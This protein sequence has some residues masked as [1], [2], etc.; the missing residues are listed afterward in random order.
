MK[1][2]AL[3]TAALSERLRRPAVVHW[4]RLEPRPRSENFDRSLRA[5]VRDALW[6]L[7]RQW[8][9]GEFRGEDAGS[10]VAAELQVETTRLTRYAHR[11]G[12]A[13]AYD[14]ELPLEAKVEREEVPLDLALRLQ[15]GHHWFRLLEQKGLTNKYRPLFRG[16]YAVAPP[17]E[18]SVAAAAALSNRA[19]LQ[20][21]AAAARRATDGGRLLEDL[22]S[23]ARAEDVTF[24]VPGTTQVLSVDAADRGAVAEAAAE[25]VAYF[26]RL[27]SQPTKEDGAAWSPEHLEYQFACS[28]PRRG[29]GQTVL[30]A[31]EYYQ[32]RLDW[33]SFDLAPDDTTLPDAKGQ[34]FN[35]NVIEQERISFIPTEVRF[36]GMP[37]ARWWEFEDGRTDFGSV[38]AHTTDIAKLL[39]MEF[40]LVYGNDWSLVPL[41]T[42]AGSISEIKA[43]VVTD[44]F[45]QRTLVR[46]AAHSGGDDTAAQRWRMFTLT[47]P[48]GGRRADERLFLPPAVGRAL[49]GP[50]VESVNF[51]RD[52]MANMVWAV[53][54]TIP[55][56]LGGGMNGY[57]AATDLLEFIRRHAPPPA[58]DPGRVENDARI[59]YRLATTVPE[60]WIPF[61]PVHLEGSTRE[62]QLQRAAMPRVVGGLAPA[63][64]TPRGVILRPADRTLYFVHEEEV[65][66][67]GAVIT[68]SFQRTRWHG[69]ATRLWL[70]RRKENGRGEGSSGLRFDQLVQQE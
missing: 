44:V 13:V 62:I 42:P 4:N 66:R 38:D 53:E 27:F 8:Q 14:G 32:G 21:R 49:E 34:V 22:H 58:P 68:R 56:D 7:T 45:G 6:L 55:D 28:A 64:V 46:S 50:P 70:G 30:V 33:Y 60:N 16:A 54:S 48:P 25:F 47:A 63:A 20:V 10:P 61:I 23:G 11:E 19:A 29:G 12:A 35:D 1:T 59:G 57:E 18:P 26:A 37:N 3:V 52:E 15:L 9:F 67:A 43:L 41:A 69:G 24:Q 40:G 39:L 51:L 36:S 65:P 17:P 2:P 5:E 31:D